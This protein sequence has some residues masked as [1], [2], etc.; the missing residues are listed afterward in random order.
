MQGSYDSYECGLEISAA[1]A[2]D[3]G[4]WACELESYVK[5]GLRGDG[6]MAEVTVLCQT[7]WGTV[8]IVCRNLSKLC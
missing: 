4:D 1:Q 3:E 6:E 8:I 7:E 2:E 5:A